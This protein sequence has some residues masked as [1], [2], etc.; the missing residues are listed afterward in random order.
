[1]LEVMYVT[2]TSR[3]PP[4]SAPSFHTSVG[5]E[6]SPVGSVGNRMYETFSLFRVM[7]GPAPRPWSSTMDEPSKLTSLPVN[8]SA[9]S[10][11][12][13]ISVSRY[14]SRILDALARSNR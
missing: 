1:M 4:S 3:S 14:F 13:S 5:F 10:P 7:T 9:S 2:S 8:R 11:I 12:T 6:M